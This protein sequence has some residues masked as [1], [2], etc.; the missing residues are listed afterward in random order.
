MGTFRVRAALRIGG[1]VRPLAL[2]TYP[3]PIGDADTLDSAYHRAMALVLMHPKFR[4]GC[5]RT[6]RAVVADRD[7]HAPAAPLVG[8]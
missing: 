3:D 6:T 1:Q 4:F 7:C 8:T 5:N 2:V